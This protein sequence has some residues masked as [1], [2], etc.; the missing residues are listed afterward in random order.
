LQAVPFENL[1]I[2]LGTPI[3]LDESSI[4][5]KIVRRRRGGFCYEL[6]SAFRWLLTHLG[7]E[8]DLLSAEVAGADGGYGIPFDHMALSVIAGGERFLADVGFGESF[9]SPFPLREAIVHEERDYRY[10]LRREREHLLLERAPTGGEPFAPQYR[11]T[12]TPRRLEEFRDGCHYHQTSPDSHFTQSVVATRALADGRV[13]LSRN[14]L[15]FRRGAERTELPILDETSW[16]NALRDH[17]D[18]VLENRS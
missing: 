12:T 2:H 14:R 1:D 11:F 5:E 15:V 6:N 16:K 10:R 7:F 17:F 13:T 18:I 3:V 9:T 4:L 8:V